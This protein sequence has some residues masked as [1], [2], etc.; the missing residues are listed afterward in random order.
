MSSRKRSYRRSNPITAIV[1][2]FGAERRRKARTQYV[3][4]F[5]GPKGAAVAKASIASARALMDAKDGGYRRWMGRGAYSLGKNY[6]KIAQS[7]FGR[8]VRKG[9]EGA[10]MGYMFG[11]PA[12][13][14]AGGASGGLAG[15]GLYTG[16][17]SYNDNSL[18]EGGDASM[19]FHG[20]FDE[21]EA[22]TIADTEYVTDIYGPPSAAFNVQSFQLNPGLM[23]NF[24]KLSQFAQNFEEYEW[25]QLIWQFK[26]TLDASTVSNGQTGTIMMATN[27]NA[28]QPPYSDKE[29]V[30]QSHG[31]NG[32]RITEDLRHGV[33]CDPAKSVGDMEKYVRTGPVPAAEDLKTYD[34]GLFQIAINNCPTTFN[35]QQLG[36]LW[37][38]YQVKLRKPRLFSA[39]G[40][41]IQ[42]D[43]FVSG[44]LTETQNFPMG[45]QQTLLKAQ[46]NNI[47]CAI[48]LTLNVIKIVF[49]AQLT[50]A[51]KVQLRLEQRSATTATP[52]TTSDV[53]G[54]TSVTGQV[55]PLNNIY[56]A[57]GDEVDSPDWRSGL[58]SGV[59]TTSAVYTFSVYLRAATGGIDNA[60]IIGVAGTS[61]TTTAASTSSCIE[62]V[63]DNPSFFAN[64]TLVPAPVLVNNITGVIANAL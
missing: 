40:N 31:G 41:S 54:N 21:S 62:I 56:A 11:G 44:S 37:V 61:F 46:Q 27:Y 51:F 32:G 50:G 34:H 24:P 1:R 47:G 36:E 20:G 12:G 57:G 59:A 63:E 13:A 33:E 3:E 9:L 2:E 4:D 35:N 28:A 64:G 17:G 26:S 8:S 22:L 53:K 16:R 58:P 42:K 29:A 45:N 48:V 25:I 23:A 52:F 30:L 43:I 19:S 14:V 60:L 18:I 6:R 49:P 10:A 15:S 7:K 38:T 39:R 5:F 55:T